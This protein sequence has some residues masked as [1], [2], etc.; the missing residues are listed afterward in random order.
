MTREKKLRLELAKEGFCFGP[1][2]KAL[3]KAIGAKIKMYPQRGIIL[4]DTT[5]N[6]HEW[7]REEVAKGNVV[8][9]QNHTSEGLIY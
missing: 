2:L 7:I 9:L 6:K 1:T 4:F 8:R 5:L 3:G